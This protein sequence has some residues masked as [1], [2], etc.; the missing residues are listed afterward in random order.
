MNEN[1]FSPL[2]MDPFRKEWEKKKTNP[3]DPESKEHRNRD[4]KIQ[5]LTIPGLEKPLYYYS[6]YSAYFLSDL[7]K[8]KVEKQFRTFEDDEGEEWKEGAEFEKI[9]TACQEQIDNQVRDNGDQPFEIDFG[10]NF[11]E[12][13]KKMNLLDSAEGY[14]HFYYLPKEYERDV[15]KYNEHVVAKAKKE[16]AEEFAK[17]VRDINLN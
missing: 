8:I 2:D 3:T 15:L 12:R 11:D 10:Y 4:E 6:G 14:G 1:N 16:A 13:L 7:N 17:Q 9:M 5:T